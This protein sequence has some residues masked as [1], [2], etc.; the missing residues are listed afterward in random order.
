M[1][2]ATRGRR[3]ELTF[4]YLI[5][6]WL[7]PKHIPIKDNAENMAIKSLRQIPVLENINVSTRNKVK[8]EPCDSPS[9][10]DQ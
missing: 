9:I 7:P 4:S 2:G 10:L 8:T 1:E 3:M 5:Y 6:R